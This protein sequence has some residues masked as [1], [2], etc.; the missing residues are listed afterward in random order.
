M[1]QAAPVHGF[2]DLVGAE[3]IRFSAARQARLQ[4]SAMRSCEHGVA[5]EQGRRCATCLGSFAAIQAQFTFLEVAT[6]GIGHL[7]E[8]ADG[9]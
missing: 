1:S 6:T 4:Y 8:E 9:H 5:E 7:L 3:E 2:D